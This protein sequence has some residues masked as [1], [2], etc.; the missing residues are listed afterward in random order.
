MTTTAP[1]RPSALPV[2]VDPIPVDLRV[3]PQWVVWRYTWKPRAA[4]WDKPPYRARGGAAASHSD[5][6]TW[7][8]FDVALGAYRAGGWD[9]IGFVVTRDDRFTGIDLDK[10]RDPE[11]GVIEPWAAEI[12]DAFDSYTEASPSGTGLRVWIAASLAGL[13]PTEADGTQ[14]DGRRTGSIEVYHAR[15]FFTV[16]GHRLNGVGR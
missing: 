7:A 11:S 2:I 10:C 9:G 4:K 8:P 12:V 1:A 13:L 14:K 3:H 15:R 16:T 5:P 6:A